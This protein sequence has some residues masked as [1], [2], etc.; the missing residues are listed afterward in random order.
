MVL[1]VGAGR[2]LRC[3]EHYMQCVKHV[4]LPRVMRGEGATGGFVDGE[5]IR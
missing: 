2:H 4:T 5:E 1:C 3:L